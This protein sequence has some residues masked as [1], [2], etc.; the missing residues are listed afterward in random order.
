[1]NIELLFEAQERY[2]S[3]I[4]ER[5]HQDKDKNFLFNLKLALLVELGEFANNWR[6]FKF[7]SADK[8]PKTKGIKEENGVKVEYDPL[9]EE[10]V[11]CLHFILSLSI[12]SGNKEYVLRILKNTRF[13]KDESEDL[14]INFIRLYNVAVDGIDIHNLVKMFKLLMNIGLRLGYSLDDI[15]KAYYKKNKDNVNRQLNGY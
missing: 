3:K 5:F 2:E 6:G 12:N 13:E 10:F 11:D 8:K 15:E 14:V 9:L 4:K 1:M 7:W